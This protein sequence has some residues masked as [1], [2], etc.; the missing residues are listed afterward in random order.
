MLVLGNSFERRALHPSRQLEQTVKSKFQIKSYDYTSQKNDCLPKHV[1]Q[2]VNTG[3]G[4]NKFSK[5][6]GRDFKSSALTSWAI[7]TP[8]QCIVYLWQ[9]VQ[10]EHLYP[11]CDSPLQ[12][13]ARRKASTHY[14]NRAEITVLMSEGRPFPL[15]VSCRHKNYP[16]QCENRL[17]SG[18]D[19][20]LFMKR[21]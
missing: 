4:A 1:E 7:F 18:S 16:V 15:W 6:L 20:Q 21:T 9:P 13:S 11:T 14:R 8:Y 19:A 5:V 17:R 12:R 3:L 10:Y 2:G